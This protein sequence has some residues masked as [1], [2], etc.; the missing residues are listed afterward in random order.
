MAY[1]DEAGDAMQVGRAA[2]YLA[3]V[4]SNFRGDNAGALQIAQPHWDALRGVRGAE[5]VLLQLSRAIALARQ[6]LNEIDFDILVARC[7]LADSLGDRAS[8]AHA[9]GSLAIPM[10]A[11]SPLLAE[12][13]CRDALEFAIE[14]QV[15]RL[16]ANSRSTLA[17]MLVGKNIA[18]SMAMY[19]EA[20][21]EGRR[22]GLDQ[23]NQ[24]VFDLNIASRGVTMGGWADV[25][26]FL[27]ASYPQSF[28]TEVG[29]PWIDALYTDVSGNPRRIPSISPEARDATDDPSLISYA[30]MTEM[31]EARDRGELAYAARLGLDA[32]IRM[33]EVVGLNDDMI[34]VWP[35]AMDTALLAGDDEALRELFA[36]VDDMPPGRVQVGHRAFRERIAALV[37][38]RD[39]ASEE[40]DA[41][42]LAAIGNF[43]EWG[44]T[45][46][47]ARARAE[48]AAWLDAQ[49]RGAEASVH[50]QAALAVLTDLGAR[51]W[52]SRLGLG[53]GDVPTADLSPAEVS[54]GL[55]GVT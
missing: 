10:L 20:R 3:M 19:K 46:H 38:V 41:H 55:G 34:F 13:L 22:S 21:E 15:S 27:S 36:V 33:V 25:E 2:A 50:R 8:F 40:V 11:T 51:G 47:A 54:A 42:F 14:T 31:Y 9:L 49:G 45:L 7:A 4:A 17:S 52:L 39:G 37:A 12:M 44:S 30:L 43:E 24:M 26:H 18:E 35:D 28:L 16:V 6:N 23:L 5:P 29:L 53:G 1:Y 48:F 32:T